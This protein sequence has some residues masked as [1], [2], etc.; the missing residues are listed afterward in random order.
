MIVGGENDYRRPPILI[1]QTELAFL[2]P[3]C[4]V[5]RV[6]N[7]STLQRFTDSRFTLHDSRL[8]FNESRGESPLQRPRAGG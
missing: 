6:I 7:A 4:G 8:R 5:K 1:A 3:D 2:R